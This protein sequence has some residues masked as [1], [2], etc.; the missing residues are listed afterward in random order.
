MTSKFAGAF[1]DV[2]LLEKIAQENAGPGVA[3]VWEGDPEPVQGWGG[4]GSAG[5]VDANADSA[6]LA[7]RLALSIVSIDPRF[8][9]DTIRRYNSTTHKIELTQAGL[10]EF[11]L[12]LAVTSE[13]SPAAMTVCERMRGRWL[14]KSTLARLR[15]AKI[16]LRSIGRTI[17]GPTKS[18]D[19]KLV[20]VAI[21]ELNMTYLYVEKD[22]IGEDD[23]NWIETVTPLTLTEI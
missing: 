17:P 7:A 1:V 4:L 18:W 14:R 15:A 19:N 11:V 8:V 23:G 16:A 20:D 3:V 13:S 2:D 9:D 6:T 22:P 12:Q 21:V 5:Q 10:R